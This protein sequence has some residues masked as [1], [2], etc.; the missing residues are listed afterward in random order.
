MGGF[1][2]TEL[3]DIQLS[4]HRPIQVNKS[5]LYYHLK[6]Q[7]SRVRCQVTMASNKEG[8]DKIGRMPD[9][10]CTLTHGSLSQAFSQSKNRSIGRNYVE[11][12]FAKSF[13]DVVGISTLP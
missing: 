11:P 7:R 2:N 8:G 10:G 12:R 9:Q 1:E 4:A 5:P 13:P 3:D 6:R